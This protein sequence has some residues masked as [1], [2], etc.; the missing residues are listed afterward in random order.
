MGCRDR[1]RPT[2][3]R[4]LKRLWERARPEIGGG[5][6]LGD[7]WAYMPQHN[8]IYAPTRE[9]WPGEQSSTPA[10]RDPGAEP[11]GAPK[12]N[13]KGNPLEIPPSAWLDQN[14][15]VEQM[16][17][18]PG[19]PMIIEERLI[20][21]GG[22]IERTGVSCFNLYRPPTLL[23]GEAK[24]AGTLAR[25]S[26]RYT[27]T[28]PPISSAGW[29][30]GC[31]ARVRNQ[32]RLGARRQARHRQG[33]DAAAG[34]DGGRAVEFSRSLADQLMGRFNGSPKPWCCA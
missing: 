16:T 21:E 5:V 3:G 9:L 23:Y 30:T 26:P 27:R 18:A 11:N 13:K 8:Y 1:A 32:S 33:H 20:S 22:W 6:S 15:P 2:G 28:T 19:E 24:Q 7:F 17:W 14:K 12:L 10:C 4:E 29:R 25:L 31:S 34:E